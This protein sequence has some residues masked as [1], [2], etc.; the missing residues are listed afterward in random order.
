MVEALSCVGLRL[1]LAWTLGCV[2]LEVEAVSGVRS[3]GCVGLGVEAN[4]G[5]VMFRLLYVGLGLR[6]FRVCEAGA[7]FEGAGGRRPSPPT[8]GK[9]KK[10]KKER[11]KKEKKRKKRK[12]EGNYE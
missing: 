4:V 7:S 8:Q 10:R 12:K 5:H 9:K 2:G 11:K 6:L 1:C 3:L